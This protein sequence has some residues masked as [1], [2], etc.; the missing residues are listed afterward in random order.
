MSSQVPS[1][2]IAAIEDLGKL[3]IPTGHLVGRKVAVKH[4]LQGLAVALH[5][6][7]HIFGRAGASFD[8]ENTRAALNHFVEKAD[9]FE[10]L[11]THHVLRINLQ[12]NVALGVLDVILAAA[13]LKALPPIGAFSPRVQTHETAAA[14]CDAERP[15]TEN[16]DF[17]AFARRPADVLLVDGSRD[18][19]GLLKRQFTSKNSDIGKVR[20]KLQRF[21]VGDVELRGKMHGDTNFVRKHHRRYIRT[22]DGIN[23]R[24]LGSKH[25]L[26][27][28]GQIFIV[29]HGINR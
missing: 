24:L 9:R 14:L 10:I 2:P 25:R 12:L 4:R 3:V 28:L 6:R 29:E 1:V 16:F 5:G 23:A 11:R 27:S 13:R 22:D 7:A 17:D 18:C 21:N 19:C 15:M 20:I 26:T 8:F